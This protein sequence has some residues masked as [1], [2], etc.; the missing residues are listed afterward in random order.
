MDN[1][2]IID[3]IKAAGRLNQIAALWTALS[4]VL[5]ALA[6]VIGTLS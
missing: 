3:A 6:S 2:A 5:A 1:L 4:V